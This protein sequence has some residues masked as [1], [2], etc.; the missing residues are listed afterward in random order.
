MKKLWMIF[1]LLLPYF[2]LPTSGDV[3]IAKG[4]LQEKAFTLLSEGENAQ[5]EALFQ[6]IIKNHGE[7]NETL[8]GLA[9]SI[10]YQNRLDESLALFEKAVSDYNTAEAWFFKGFNHYQLGHLNEAEKDY[11][12]GIDLGYDIF[13]V[14][15]NLGFMKFSD[16]KYDE[17][18]ILF[19][20][21][22]DRNKE[23]DKSWY[24]LALCRYRQ[25]LDAFY[26][27]SK[28]IEINPQFTM[29]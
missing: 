20:K 17:G 10:L 19:R 23:H 15:F 26:E 12:K 7:S 27:F 11:L 21:S 18:E 5:A 8:I 22:L 1:F 9:R 28:T 25:N 13:D 6:K 2:L 29:A 3:Q 14:Y 24:Y 16:N 4:T